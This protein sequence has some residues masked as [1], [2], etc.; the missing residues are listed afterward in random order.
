MLS[1]CVHLARACRGRD[2]ARRSSNVRGAY[3]VNANPLVALSG[4]SNL[5]SDLRIFLRRYGPFGVQKWLR[6]IDE[7]S[8]IA[9][10]FL[11]LRRAL[12]AV[13]ADSTIRVWDLSAFA[14]PAKQ[15]PISARTDAASASASAEHASAAVDPFVAHPTAWLGSN[16]QTFS[17]LAAA[18]TFSLTLS[19]EDDEEN[20]N[21]ACVMMH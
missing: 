5:R 1:R 11:P 2:H 6:S 3:L 4:P 20:P 17:V 8:V 9:V 12:L 19:S 14:S 18:C 7:H 21:R 10:H 15:A 16:A 13:S